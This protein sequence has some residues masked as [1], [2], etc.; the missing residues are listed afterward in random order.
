MNRP[1]HL[2]LNLRTGEVTA[3]NVHPNYM[4]HEQGYI[5]QEP[6]PIP[7][8]LTRNIRSFMTEFYEEGSFEFS[9]SAYALVGLCSAIE[10][11]RSSET[12]IWC[13]RMRRFSSE[14]TCGCC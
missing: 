8:R 9:V 1:A 2:L 3:L 5:V 6:S 12:R 4:S 13:R 14:I 7:F 10:R 11:R